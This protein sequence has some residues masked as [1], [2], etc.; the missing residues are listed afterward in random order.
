MTPF[1]NQSPDRFLP[2]SIPGDRLLTPCLS[3]DLVTARENIDRV[4]EAIGDPS[5]W[6]PHLKTTKLPAIWSLLLEAGVERFKC[7][8]TR[9][10]AVLLE[11]APDADILLAHHLAPAT[12]DRLAR[13]AETFPEARLSALVETVEAVE[14]LPPSIGAFVD[15]DPG[16]HRS[17]IP[18]TDMAR[19]SAVTEACGPRWRGI[20]YYDG[21]LRDEDESSRRAR[22]H[23]GYDR[24]L[25]IDAALGGASE[26]ITSGTPTFLHALT[27]ARLAGTLR[28]A[29]SPGTVVLHDL[30]SQRLEEVARLGLRPAAVVLAHVVSRPGEDLVTLNAGHK[31][32]SVDSGDPCCLALGHET[33]LPLHPS[34]EHLPVRVLEGPRPEPGTLLALVPQHVCPTVNLA[35][36]ALLVNGPDED[37]VIVPVAAGGHE[38][39]L[40]GSA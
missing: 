34:E 3:I 2:G 7:A 16:M 32:I 19:I 20:H 26:L 28:H 13:L 6:R 17:G 4:L 10:M 15:V 36:H 24:L 5:C 14:A 1:A 33:L 22:A 8:T 29:V 18:V 11:L 30:V 27:H 25:E 21:H 12:G 23:A 35:R 39:T 38:P 9:E 40:P 37:A 31:A